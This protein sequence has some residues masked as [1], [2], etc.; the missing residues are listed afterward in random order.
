VYVY[1]HVHTTHVCRG[2]PHGSY[3][4]L[5]RMPGFG[6]NDG[7]RKRWLAS[8][9]VSAGLGPRRRRWIQRQTL[10]RSYLQNQNVLERSYTFGD[11]GTGLRIRD[12]NSP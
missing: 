2:E 6:S 11:D 8:A 12:I 4:L 9:H 1:S 7:P 3:R 5:I 10:L